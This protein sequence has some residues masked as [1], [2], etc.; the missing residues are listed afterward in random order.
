MSYATI[1]AG[2]HA[3]L[4][5]VAGLNAVLDYVPTAVHDPPIVYSLLQRVSITR[6][7][8]VRS[9]T[10]RILHR[11]VIRW[12]DNEQAEIEASPFVDSIPLAVEADPQLGGALISGYAD[13]S[14]CESGFAEIG[15]VVYRI[16]DFYAT[17][18]EKSE[19]NHG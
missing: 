7:G 18:V 14:E 12:Q 1:L 2:L 6:S 3:R 16:L 17:V 8:Q 11:V 4:E 9:T 5:T 15:E 19:V 10:Y 13:I